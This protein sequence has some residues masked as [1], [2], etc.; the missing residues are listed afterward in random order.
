MQ[1][2]CDING[3]E[4]LVDELYKDYLPIEFNKIVT[5]EIGQL[6]DVRTFEEFNNGHLDNAV[7]VDF[8]AADFQ[9]QMIT[10]L[11]KSEPVYLYCH[12]GRRSGLAA[13]MLNQ[14]GFKNVYNLKG[15]IL[16]WEQENF[17]VKDSKPME[18]GMSIN[19]FNQAIDAKELCLVNFYAPWC[20]PCK[21]MG[22]IWQILKSE[23]KKLNINF[24]RLNVDE[25][26]ALAKELKVNSLPVVSFYKNGI[27]SKTV[28]G[29]QD[30][31]ALR[32]I[33]NQL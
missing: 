24:I 27:E 16:L 10:T 29:F 2:L 15:G 1:D 23:M 31:S 12:S 19:D 21:E 4:P 11:S 30:E 28:Q 6:V 33:I 7:N 3:C 26:K 8:Y 5:T 18:V 17:F 13:E 32:D 20:P 9:E 25:N 14:A 22:P